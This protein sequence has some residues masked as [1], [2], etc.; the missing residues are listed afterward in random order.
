MA[1]RAQRYARVVR[2]L[3]RHTAVRPGMRGVRSPFDLAQQ[4]KVQ[5]QSLYRIADP[6]PREP[7]DEICGHLPQDGN[8]LPQAFSLLQEL[9]GAADLFLGTVEGHRTAISIVPQSAAEIQPPSD[10]ADIQ[11]EARPFS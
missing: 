1:V 2:G 8:G 11:P 9:L 10:T 5:I 4:A 3:H 7:G 6:C